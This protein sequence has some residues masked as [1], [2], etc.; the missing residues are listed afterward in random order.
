MSAYRDS[1]P[2]EM[3][4][5]YDE[6]VSRAALALGHARARRDSLT[7]LDAARA[8]HLP[9]GPSVE[10]LTQRI[11]QMRAEVRAELLARSA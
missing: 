10:E 4:S 11:T 1:L 9:G 6:A 2:P 7:P 3:R 8:A 5:R